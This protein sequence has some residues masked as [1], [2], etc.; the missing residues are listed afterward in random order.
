MIF[1]SSYLKYSYSVIFLFFVPFF[2][3]STQSYSQNF[4]DDTFFSNSVSFNKT[5]VVL[6]VNASNAFFEPALGLTN[7]F[8]PTGLFPF[9]E[10]FSCNESFKCSVNAGI[11]SYFNADF[12]EFNKQ[13]MTNFEAVYT[14]PITYDTGQI[15]DHRYKII[16]TDTM[17]NSTISAL[18]TENPHFTKMVNNVGMNQIQHGR[19]NID[20]SDIPQFYSLAYLYGHAKIIDITNN[21]NKEISKNIFTHVMVGH[22]M[23]ENIFYQDLKDEP[24]TPNLVIVILTNIP[25]DA[26]LEGIGVLTPEQTQSFMPIR[27]D[28]S[29]SN[30]PPFDYPIKSWISGKDKIENKYIQSSNWP[31]DNH[32]E[33]LIFTFL[34]FK[35]LNVIYEDVAF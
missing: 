6:R 11:N 1:K 13:N 30:P 32:D 8:G 15:K 34:I 7:F 2:L 33:P 23:D 19:S 9:K 16:L 35:D 24:I 4:S 26:D 3:P 20:R 17:W 18:P 5:D 22:F 21:T 10:I 25:D 28:P 12:E 27:D 31:V 14:S 29:L